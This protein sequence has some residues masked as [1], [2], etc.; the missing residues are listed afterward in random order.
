M[1]GKTNM[2][3]WERNSKWVTPVIAI[4]T[5]VGGLLLGVYKATLEYDSKVQIME[6]NIKLEIRQASDDVKK[7]IEDLM[8]NR[9]LTDF[10]TRLKNEFV[11]KAGEQ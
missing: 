6:A 5:F 3:W 1:D 2:S 9:V 4:I 8:Q 10:Y 11:T 7:D